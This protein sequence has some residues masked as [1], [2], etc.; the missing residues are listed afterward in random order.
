MDGQVPCLC[1]SDAEVLMPRHRITTIATMTRTSKNRVRA[2]KDMIVR[3]GGS[4]ALVDF[5][6]TPPLGSNMS[7]GGRGGTAEL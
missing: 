2:R 5:H 6:V 4:R 1:I 7:P 3:E